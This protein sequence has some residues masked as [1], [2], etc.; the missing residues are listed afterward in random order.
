MNTNAVMVYATV[1]KNGVANSSYV[2]I[3]GV[4]DGN[5]GLPA[6]TSQE[7]SPY[8]RNEITFGNI[9]AGGGYRGNI[10]IGEVLVFDTALADAA[11]R[12]VETYLNN[13]WLGASDPITPFLPTNGVVQV[14]SGA[15]LNLDS[16]S[17]T[18]ASISGEGVLSNGSLTAT[19][20]ISPAGESIGTLKLSNVALS[21]TLRV[22]V[23]TD[24][25]SDQLASSS[26]LSLTGLTLQ[27]AD[28]GLLN[29]LKSYTIVTCSGTLTGELTATLPNNWKI[30]YDRTEGAATATL[31]YIPIGS[32][33]RF[34]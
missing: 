4:S 30:K 22:N 20:T 29:W 15:V 33:V 3:N 19:G 11:R 9:N 5:S 21:G 23:A 27:I 34:M 12:N 1:L 26:N 17:H 8:G 14:A 16:A 13:K 7:N 24:G 6:F 18:V 31:V 25:A 32:M 10:Q 2:Y 28:T